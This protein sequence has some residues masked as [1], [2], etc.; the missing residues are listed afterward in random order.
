MK[1]EIGKQYQLCC[2]WAHRELGL[3]VEVLEITLSAG[4]QPMALVKVIT[5]DK[6]NT[7]PIGYTY[8]CYFFDFENSW[9]CIYFQNIYDKLITSLEA[10]T[11]A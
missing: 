4:T 2:S 11:N 3:I 1:L 6:H 9:K 10:K 8:N 7:K 5:P